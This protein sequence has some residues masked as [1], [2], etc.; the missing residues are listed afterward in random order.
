MTAPVLIITQ[1]FSSQTEDQKQQ[2]LQQI[3]DRC[4]SANGPARAAP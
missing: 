2:L 3:F 1:T 4:L